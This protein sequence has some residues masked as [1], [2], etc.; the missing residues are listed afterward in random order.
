DVSFGVR[1]ED[2]AD[3][4]QHTAQ[5]SRSLEDCVHKGSASAA[6]AV[7]EW[8]NRLELGVGDRGSDDG[9]A[10][11]AR[12]EFGEIRDQARYLGRW[13]RDEVCAQWTVSGASDPVLLR[14]ESNFEPRFD[15]MLQI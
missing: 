10:V 8:M 2:G 7:N 3:G 5:H 12:N 9:V 1:S 15:R 14:P 13:R 6:V 4:H 11:G